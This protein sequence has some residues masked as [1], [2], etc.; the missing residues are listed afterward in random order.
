MDPQQITVDHG[1]DEDHI[2]AFGRTPYNQEV[3]K[4]T[5]MNNAARAS[6]LS[7]APFWG[8]KLCMPAW[9]KKE[10]LEKF[11]RHWDHRLG[12]ETLKIQH[13]MKYGP[14]PNEK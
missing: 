12:L 8:H 7:Y 3:I 4:N 1:M 11:Y 6:T 9:Y 13:V 10:K 14:T 2:W 5:W